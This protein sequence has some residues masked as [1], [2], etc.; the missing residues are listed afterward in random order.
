MSTY[1]VDFS[2][3]QGLVRFS[4]GALT[5]ASF[6]LLRI[7]DRRAAAAW[8]AAAPVSNA[9]ERDKPPQTALQIAFT[10]EGLE[11]LGIT[12]SIISGF[13]D[14]FISGMWGPENRSRR[15]GDVGANAPATWRWGGP[16]N[17]PHVLVMAY[18]QSGLESFIASWKDAIWEKAFEC[19]APLSTS[20]LRGVEPFGFKDGISQPKLDWER[21]RNTADQ[22][23]FTNLSC[24]GEFLLGYPNEYGRYTDRPLLPADGSSAMLP[25]AEDAPG[26][27]DLG[28][29]GSYLVMRQLQ[30]DVRSFWQFADRQANGD[31][32]QR[33]YLASAMVGRK[34]DGTPLV[35]L[36][37][38]K[39]PGVEASTP[40]NQFTY[41]TDPEGTHCPFGAHIRRSNPRNADFPSG[42]RGLVRKV[43]HSLGITKAQLREDIISSTRFHRLLRRGRE[44]GPGL[45]P[46]QALDASYSDNEEH[47]IH[48]ICLNGN[49]SRQFEFVQGAWIMNTK[50][51]GMTGES[52]PLLGNRQPIPG[53]PTA[54][55]FQL[56]GPSGLSYRVC[57]VPQFI[58]VRGGAYFFLPGLKAL[59]FLATAFS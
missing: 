55:N 26:M 8:I 9:V 47:G 51:N 1:A 17:I 15:L 4:Y 31:P 59:K 27:R 5:E 36:N 14:E 18:A 13:S 21:G 42:T 34:R 2:D 39:I 22:F 29:N 3:V 58:T 7:R 52:D 50:F 35:P 20:N 11:A 25:E 37:S 41:D 10:R 44:Y 23:E 43:F 28:R 16:E 54:D 24:L 57:G 46:E 12:E 6:L 33:E 49:I 56:A 32:Q 38:T 30:Q 40:S 19:V 53:Q 48:F 45:S